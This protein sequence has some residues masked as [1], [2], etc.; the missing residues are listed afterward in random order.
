MVHRLWLK[1][2]IHID[3]DVEYF[4]SKENSLEEE[5][6]QQLQDLALI[7]DFKATSDLPQWMTPQERGQVRAFLLAAPAVTQLSR[8]VY[9]L[10]NRVVD[11]SSAVALPPKSQGLTALWGE[12]LGWLGNWK[13]V[14]RIIKMLDDRALR[15]RVSRI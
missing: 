15:G 6:K 4:E 10:D 14:L 12:F 1:S 7:C 2:L 13:L 8:Y 5:H 11:F 3:P 9:Q